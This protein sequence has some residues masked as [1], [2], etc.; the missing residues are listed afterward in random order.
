MKP[1]IEYAIRIQR[2]RRNLSDADFARRIELLDE[3]K[4]K[5]ENLRKGNKIPEGSTEP[6]G[7][8]SA[9]T[10]AKKAGTSAS[11][12]KKFR[13]VKKKKPELIEKIE[14]GE[15]SINKAYNEIKEDVKSEERSTDKKGGDNISVDRSKTNRDVLGFETFDE[16]IKV[17][18]DFKKSY[19]KYL[20]SSA[21]VVDN[22]SGMATM[23]A[24]PSNERQARPLTRLEPEKQIEA[25]QND[26]SGM[27][28]NGN[29][30]LATILP[31]GGQG[32]RRMAFSILT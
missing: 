18:W 25:W 23:V 20:I 24:K 5:N 4:D 29:N 21:S 19:A 1:A 13:A 22:L 15:M 14:S 27:F 28:Q 7:E 10:T 2:D 9:E 8:S 31:V 30:H 17:K 12:V 16:Y 11:K 26:R 32:L 3:V 6:S